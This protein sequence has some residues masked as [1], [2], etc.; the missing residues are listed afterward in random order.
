MLMYS[1]LFV[2]CIAFQELI[3]LNYNKEIMS[4][5]IVRAY[6]S[7]GCIYYL[8]PILWDTEH[9]LMEIESTEMPSDV[10]FVLK[11]SAYFFLWDTFALLM[12]NEKEK[13]VYILHHL[14]SCFT[15]AYSLYYEIN[16]YF[17]SIGLFLAEITNPTTQISEA[18]T[19]FNY[20]N[21]TFEKFYFMYMLLIRG[22]L[23]PCMV[24]LT[25]YDLKYLL[26]I[27]G[28]DVFNRSIIINYFTMI[29]ITLASIDWLNNK[30]EQIII[31]DNKR[32]N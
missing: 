24:L 32:L 20:Y 26:S 11:R 7:I 8:T 6:H 4:S 30:Y 9:A 14:M 29:S 23:C 12:G 21:N 28:E 13:I 18:C 1:F 10:N 25:L 31:E 15:I 17:V 5:I 16:W 22:I 19:L 27:H 3:P 2:V